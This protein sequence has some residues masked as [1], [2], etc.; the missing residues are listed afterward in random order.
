MRTILI[1]IGRLGLLLTLLPA[2]LLLAGVVTLST[3]KLLMVV[4]M[5][6]WFVSAPISQHMAQESS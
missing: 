3:T 6:L 1:S 5:V 4:G 2:V